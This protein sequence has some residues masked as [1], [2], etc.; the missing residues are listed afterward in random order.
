LSFDCAALPPPDLNHLVN[1]AALESHCAA[2]LYVRKFPAVG[3]EVNGMMVDS[4]QLTHIPDRHQWIVHNDFSLKNA[5]NPPGFLRH[6]L[7]V[8]LSQFVVLSTL[9]SDHTIAHSKK[10]KKKNKKITTKQSGLLCLVGYCLD[11][12]GFSFGAAPFF[13]WTVR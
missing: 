13:Y 1:V 12:T 10:D 11:S 8:S 3:P 2:E 9:V 6:G 4:E 7:P 5:K